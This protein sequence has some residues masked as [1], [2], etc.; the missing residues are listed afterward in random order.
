MKTTKIT[1]DRIKKYLEE[2]KRFDG[3][4]LDDFRDIEVELGVSKNAEGSAR[5]KLGKT[6][7]IVGVKIDVTEPY[8]DSPDDGNLMVTAEL[9]A[10]SSPRFENG[11]PQFNAIELGRV[12]DRGIRESKVIETKKLCIKPG[13][14]VWNIYIDIYSINHD[15]NLLDAAGIAA[16]IALKNSMMPKYDEKEGKIIHG[17]WSDE[18]LPMAKDP[19]ISTTFYKIGKELVVDPTLEEEDVAKT[20]ITVG[21][22]NGVI[23]SIQKSGEGPFSEEEIAKALDMSGK[24]WSDVHK[25]IEKFL[26]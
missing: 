26:K 7:V 5:V 10:M 20:K 16:I 8:P 2:G 23:S 18:K 24:V 3:R 14:K 13:E 11:P 17:E 19:P 9:A 25:K 12:V 15:G 21:S 6:D 22:A 1:G 4:N